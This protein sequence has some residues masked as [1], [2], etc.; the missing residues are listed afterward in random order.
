MNIKT[1]FSVQETAE[2]SVNDIA[3]QFEMFDT[4]MV[5]FFSSTKYA[6]E[7]ISSLMQNAF[8]MAQVF[9]CTTAGE[10][11]SGKMLENSIVAMAFNGQAIKDA[12]I[13]VIENLHDENA[14]RAALESFGSY[15]NE[16]VADM[17]PATYV[18]IILV[19]GL[20]GAEEGLMETIGDLTNVT[21]IGGSAGDDLKF[22]STKVYAQGKSYSNAAVLAMLKP[23][24][25]F[26]FIK[27]QSF[28]DLG[29]SLEV[30]KAIEAQR[31]VVEFNGKPAAVAYA[32]AVGTSVEEAAKHFMHNP[33]GLFIE[34]EPYVRSPQ[35]IKGDSMLFYCSVMEGMELSLL[36]GTDMIGD[37][38]Q[39]LE[40]AK[41]ELGSISGLV[42]FNCILRTLE[43]RQ[44]NLEQAYGELFANIPTVGFSSYGEEYIGHINQTAT[45]LVFK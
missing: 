24:V 32:E 43:L 25:E 17:D 9:G 13:E 15:F 30:T 34:D 40:L 12:K 20:S 38:R 42:A 14:V 41:S 8:P 39:A 29:K 36:E 11:A 26:S 7:S 10:I 35:Q 18:G 16:P 19:D 1:A 44:N 5:L 2:R 45:M 22:A 6:P 33:V 37:T 28:R 3:R 27:T 23:G 31:E 21:F 4:E